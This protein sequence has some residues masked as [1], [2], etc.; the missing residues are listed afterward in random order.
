VPTVPGSGSRHSSRTTVFTVLGLLLLVH[1]ILGVGVARALDPLHLGKGT[2][3]LGL[4]IRTRGE[5][6]HGYTVKGPANGAD[7]RALLLR[8]RILGQYRH[9]HGYRF[10]LELQDSRYTG[11]RLAPADFPRTCPFEDQLDIHQAFAE[12]HLPLRNILVLKAGRQVITY[13]DRR[14]FGPGNWGNVGR[15]WWDA[16]KLS[17][18]TGPVRTDLLWGQR[19]IREPGRLDTDHYPFHL[20]GVYSMLHQPWGQLHLFVLE[21]RSHRPARGET[22]VGR[23]RVRTVGA[24]VHTQPGP[25]WILEGTLA[26][27]RGERGGD[28]VRAWGG[29]LLF[30]RRFPARSNPYVG[31]E[32]AIGSGDRDP[33]D[34]IAGTFDG[35]FGSV[36]GAY[37]RMN[38]FCW[39]NL[40]DLVLTVGF[41]PWRETVVWLDLHH[42]ELDSASDAWYWCSG[43]PLLRD[44]LG[45]HGRQLGHELDLLFKTRLAPHWSLFA[46]AGFF[47]RGPF[48]ERDPRVARHL[49]WGFVQLTLSI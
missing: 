43:K 48:L 44:P 35:V 39:K 20:L 4:Q 36:S 31:A 8:T 42:F 5:F 23:S 6:W 27:Q 25:R 37:G 38:L 40:R 46:G 41:H 11:S 34:G 10:V 16:V 17:F 33:G 12:F 19:V 45:R 18:L 22:G 9:P 26:L 3:H 14:I 30:R 28:E 47:R 2:F 21:R 1:A 13:A 24:W 29:H 7:D 15:Y 32:L 49:A